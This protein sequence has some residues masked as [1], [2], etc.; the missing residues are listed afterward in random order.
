MDSLL[1]ETG[2]V[3]QRRPAE[4]CER[5]M[6]FS[7]I[8]LSA[9]CRIVAVKEVAVGV[10]AAA[11]EMVGVEVAEDSVEGVKGVAV[12]VEVNPPRPR[13]HLPATTP[14]ASEVDSRR[15]LILSETVFMHLNA[16]SFLPIPFLILFSGR[17]LSFFPLPKVSMMVVFSFNSNLSNFSFKGE[18]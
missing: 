9:S 5:S 17:R 14:Y 6:I 11:V 13:P 18:L 12:E 1:R 3:R 16:V 15:P 7:D 8:P 2:T 4:E 10:E